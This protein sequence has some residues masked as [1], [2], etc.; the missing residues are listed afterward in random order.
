MGTFFSIF[1]WLWF[2]VFVEF[3]LVFG[4]VTFCYLFYFVKFKCGGMFASRLWKNLLPW[5][6][7]SWVFFMSMV[8]YHFNF[9]LIHFYWLL[10]LD[11]VLEFPALVSRI[12]WKPVI[13]LLLW[14]S[15]LIWVCWIVKQITVLQMCICQCLY[16]C[17]YMYV[18]IYTYV[19]VCMYMYMCMY[20][21]KCICIYV[22]MYICI[23]IYIYI[24]FLLN[25]YFIFM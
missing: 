25:F 9:I 3:V 2:L 11:S 6:H 4:F 24:S 22:R 12:L 20:M 13:W 19:F 14:F 1:I 8:F 16:V 15:W 7:S 18:C 23:Y 10:L 17:A 5:T 21:Y